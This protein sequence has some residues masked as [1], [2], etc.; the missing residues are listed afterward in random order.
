M[1]DREKMIDLII[2]FGCGKWK[3]VPFAL[4]EKNGGRFEWNA[5]DRELSLYFYPPAHIDRS[6]WEECE[7][8][9]LPDG[10][11]ASRLILAETCNGEAKY[12]PSC[13]RPLTEEALAELERRL[14]G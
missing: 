14:R 12:C 8:C 10:K 13:G 3:G 5:E 2:N 4:F 1:T 6:K 7:L 11:T 9:S